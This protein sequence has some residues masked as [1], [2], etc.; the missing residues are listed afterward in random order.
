MLILARKIGEGVV[1]NENVTVRIVDIS[2]GI[3]KL[4]FD[5]PKDMLILREELQQAVKETNTLASQSV[6]DGSLFDLSKKLK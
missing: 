4:G 5:A 1:L 3:V 2:K 6:S